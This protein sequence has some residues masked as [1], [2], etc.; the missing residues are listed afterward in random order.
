MGLTK[1]CA[2]RERGLIGFGV[3][4]REVVDKDMVSV[5]AKPYVIWGAAFIMRGF[6][7]D[8]RTACLA[9]QGQTT[10]PKPRWCWQDPAKTP[11]P[12]C[13]KASRPNPRKVLAM[14]RSIRSAK[15]FLSD[16]AL[17]LKMVDWAQA[18]KIDTVLD[19]DFAKRTC[20][21][22]ILRPC[23]HIIPGQR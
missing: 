14:T 8:Y 10:P 17:P 3:T 16:S 6:V 5:R 15:F 2:R 23:N 11:F 4:D 9:P 12:T 20:L 13:D 1:G 7:I 21:R 22:R 18:T 19:K